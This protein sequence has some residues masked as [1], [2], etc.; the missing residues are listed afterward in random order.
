MR[1]QYKVF[2]LLLLTAVM[3]ACVPSIASV[4]AAP[5]TFDPGSL[6]TLIAATAQAAA[7]QTAVFITPTLPPPP[8]ATNTPTP[9]ATPTVTFIF[10]LSTPTV[11]TPIPEVG[12]TGKEFDCAVLST[13]PENGSVM[14]AGS[15]FTT[16]WQLLNIGTGTWDSGSAD[17]LYLSGDKLHKA[18]I[19]DLDHD[20]DS[21]GQIDI[22][23]AM[24]AP[25]STGTYTTTWVIKTKAQEYCRMSL[26]I[27]V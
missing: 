18:S 17:V 12:S 1:R 7:T 15:D 2:V 14:A 20:V 11:P 5:P 16:V 24:K 9:T 25:S 21:G 8:T 19:Y 26:T 3:L 4:P 10:I 13:S 27:K 22:Q 6:N 23:V